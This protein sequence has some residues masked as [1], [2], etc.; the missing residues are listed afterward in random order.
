V[1]YSSFFGKNE[2]KIKMLFQENGNVKNICAFVDA[3]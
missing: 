1:I 3:S 2:K